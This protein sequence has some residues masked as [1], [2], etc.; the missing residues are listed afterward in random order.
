VDPMA[1]R[2]IARTLDAMKSLIRRSADDPTVGAA[3]AMLRSRFGQDK[4]RFVLGA[5][6]LMAAV[7][8]AYDPPGVEL[9]R[10]P[11]HFLRKL[12]ELAG[13]CDDQTVMMAS[14]LHHVSAPTRQDPLSLAV[15]STRKNKIPHHVFF[16]WNNLPLDPIMSTGGRQHPA[17]RER[18]PGWWIGS[19]EPVTFLGMTEV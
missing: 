4:R 17:T 16:T 8:F 13:D 19:E 11:D 15:V 10:S 18:W 2:T 1:E 12:G 5:W 9:V 7:P 14:L 6:K 3:V